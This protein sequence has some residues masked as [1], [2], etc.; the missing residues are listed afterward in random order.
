VARELARGVNELKRA[1]F[2]VEYLEIREAESL[3][4]VA[5]NVTVPARVFAA[6]RLGQTR[7]I[8]NM[9]IAPSRFN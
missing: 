8:D 2:A 6:V 3:L 5:A 1:G 9:P 7:L 4:P